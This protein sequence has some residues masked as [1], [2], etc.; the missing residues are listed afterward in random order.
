[1][2]TLV[3]VC[4]FSLLL[5]IGCAQPP[6]ETEAVKPAEQPPVAPVSP[7]DRWH[8]DK[9]E[10]ELDHMIKASLNDGELYIRCSP[11]FEGYIVPHLTNLGGRLDSDVDREQVVRYRIDGH[12]LRSEPWSISTDFSGLF[13]P[14]R[15]LRQVMRAKQLVIEYKPEYVEKETMTLDLSGLEEA[16]KQAGCIK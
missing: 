1:M 11:K 2:K 16:A 12:A 15:A 9:S 13:L 7:V 5:L 8:V 4:F 6:T 3:S 10:N 14:S